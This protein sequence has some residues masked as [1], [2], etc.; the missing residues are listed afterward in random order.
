[1]LFFPFHLLPYLFFCVTFEG[2]VLKAERLFYLLV[3][4]VSHGYPLIIPLCK[5]NENDNASSCI[6]RLYA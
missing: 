4:V 6:L 5:A 3:D 2:E 1:M